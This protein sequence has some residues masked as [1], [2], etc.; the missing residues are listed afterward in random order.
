MI[1]H[2]QIVSELTRAKAVFQ[3][4]AITVALELPA[5]HQPA[6]RRQDDGGE[7]LPSEMDA[8]RHGGLDR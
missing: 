5:H 7:P 2:A 3:L 1:D 6:P 8:S 4:R